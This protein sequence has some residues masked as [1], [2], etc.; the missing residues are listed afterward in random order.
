MKN[1]RFYNRKA[2]LYRPSR[3]TNNLET[4]PETPTASFKCT[5]QNIAGEDM[6]EKFGREINRVIRAYRF[7]S[8]YLDVQIWDKIVI[9]EI[10]Y[11][12]NSANVYKG[13]FRTFCKAY[14]VKWEWPE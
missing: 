9:D 5:L 3:W 14:L 8:D 10:T 2:D 13:S 12:V 11:I 6:G 1:R 7:F 4:L